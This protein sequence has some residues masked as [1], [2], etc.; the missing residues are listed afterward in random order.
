MENTQLVLTER[1]VGFCSRHGNDWEQD[2]ARF[3]RMAKPFRGTRTIPSVIACALA[4]LL[5]CSVPA[6]AQKTSS[7]TFHEEAA[8]PVVLDVTV[9]DSQGQPVVHGLE[10]ND[11]TIRQDG[12]TQTIL[13]FEM[14]QATASDSQAMHATHA[15]AMILVLDLLSSPFADAGYLRSQLRQYLEAQPE[16]LPAPTELMVLAANSLQAAQNFTRSKAAL[17]AALDKVPVASSF[18]AT[19]GAFGYD[20]FGQTVNALEQLAL[21]NRGVAGKKDIF[22]L[23]RGFIGIRPIDFTYKSQEQADQFLHRA[24]NLMV[25]ARE[26]LFVFYPPGG[27]IRSQVALAANAP[28]D[29]RNPFAQNINLGVFV[30]E[31][32]GHFYDG[33]D[34]GR[35]MAQAQEAAAQ[36]YTLR[37][38]PNFAPAN[39]AFQSIQVSVDR[40]GLQIAAPAGYFAPASAAPIEAI[41]TELAE[42]SQ[43]AQSTIAYH[44]SDL[45]VRSLIRHPDSGTELVT[46]A[47]RSTHLV[48][49]P[50]SNGKS[51]A[52]VTFAAASLSSSGQVLGYTVRSISIT[53]PTQN[54]AL[55]TASGTLV[56]ILVHV[57]PRTARVRVVAQAADNGWISSVDLDRATLDAA[58]ATRT[59]DPTLIQ[60]SFDPAAPTTQKP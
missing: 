3:H 4:L 53:S 7:D 46:I 13:S 6:Q 38:Q 34:I 24:T 18:E 30:S 59:P 39:G 57:P 51:S 29:S 25:E 22:W 47:L 48:W 36:Y 28:P 16:P 14:P 31:T 27:S 21:Q 26:S 2:E 41:R 52:D 35:E 20:R 23:G 45:T 10:R 17:L 58:P 5:R 56:S 8:S 50:G 43:A 40:S 49:H 32:G 15:P 37:Y 9:L 12:R 33:N 44:G 54:P 60:R 55:L 1:C 42:L 11:F 19:S